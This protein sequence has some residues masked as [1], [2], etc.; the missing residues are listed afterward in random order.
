MKV[1]ASL[2]P[3]DLE[4]FLQACR[5]PAVLQLPAQRLPQPFYFGPGEL[6]NHVPRR[7]A[8]CPKGPPSRSPATTTTS[9]R[10]A[11]RRG[12]KTAPLSLIPIG[13][14]ETRIPERG[15]LFR[16]VVPTLPAGSARANGSR[17]SI[18]AQSN[19]QLASLAAARSVAPSSL[20]HT[21]IPP[22]LRSLSSLVPLPSLSSF[23][24]GRVISATIASV[25]ETALFSNKRDKKEGR[26]GAEKRE[27][28]RR[29][30]HAAAGGGG[31]AE[32]LGN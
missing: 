11:C 30:L 9:C 23:H 25:M 22:P 16:G 24:A 4:A 5:P 31:F 6:S 26:F 32:G 21:Y 10:Q 27:R 14:P 18:P 1:N 7:S 28:E 29:L 13:T 15:A 20:P 8:P 19:A 3:A 17:I 2:G 12:C